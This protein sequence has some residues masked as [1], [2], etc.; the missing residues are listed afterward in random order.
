MGHM[1][2]NCPIWHFGS[3]GWCGL[4]NWKSQLDSPGSLSMM[5]VQKLFDSR[6]WHR[7]VPD[8]QHTVM[9]SGYGFWGN[10]N[11]ATA[12]LTANGNTMIAYLPS[13]RQVTVDM[14]RISG[15]QAKAWWYNP[16]DA[17]TT[18]IG[19]YATS[20]SRRFTPPSGGDW[21]LVI[22]DASLNL[23][24]PGQG[25][26]PPMDDPPSVSI[27]DPPDGSEITGSVTI[28]A[29]ATDDDGI[30]KVD[31]YVDSNLVGSDNTTPYEILWDTLTVSDG[32]HIIRAT[33]VDTASLTSSD[34]VNVTIDNVGDPLVITST[35]GTVATVGLLYTYDVEAV[36]PDA[37]D[38]LFY[39]LTRAPAGMTIDATTGLVAWTPSSSDVGDNDVEVTVENGGGLSDSQAFTITV[40]EA[41]TCLVVFAD[42]FETG[43]GHGEQGVQGP[44][45]PSAWF[46]SSQRA[47]DGTYSAEIDGQ[48]I[49]APLISSPIDL[50]GKT[51]ATI[52]FSWYIERGLDTGEYLAFDVSTDGELTW[53]EKARLRGNVDRENEWHDVRVALTEL[54]NLTLRFRATMSR[55]DE[56]AN[57]DGVT[58]TAACD[59]LVITSTPGTVAMVGLLYTYDVEAVDPDA[60]DTL[61]Y[62]LTS[63]PAGMTIDATTGLIAWT[64]SSSDVGDNDVEV[65]VE[66]G[67]GL[68][69]AQAFSITVSEAPTER[70]AFADSFESGLGN[71]R[72]D[73][74]NAWFRSSQRAGDGSYSAEV[75]GS[76]IDA[77]LISSPIDLQGRTNATI[78]FAWYIERGLDAGEYLAFDVS[79]DGGFT[80]VE[81][82]RL[83]GNVD[84]EGVRHDVRV[85]L[86]ELENLT[87]RFRGTM[88]HYSED[89]NL[90][91]VTVT[92]R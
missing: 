59:P 73:A 86:T 36:D 23:P 54:E 1:F 66:N 7:L 21:V 82:A 6:A 15:T 26:G 70:V 88:S 83:R 75:D 74:Q 28:S 79:T 60:G 34:S 52:A 40:S 17:A 4:T 61:F 22:D 10:T 2:G 55:Y 45:L 32:T 25:G 78:T 8:F 76:A 71:W 67:A 87:L 37:G 47:A 58:V 13:P 42:S 39:F 63:A 14:S 24:A 11:Y 5:Y 49:D 20:G 12:A 65:T 80:W 3:S 35:P 33:A 48:A 90:D 31:F 56:D 44:W 69:G 77:Q 18:E 30:S 29:D 84:R 92:A 53:V 91:E 43:G 85:A 72:Q 51:H 81:K 19:T 38:T 27:T 41:Q 62:F 89:A 68:S 16:S 46:S 64:P 57:V 50:Q 9:T